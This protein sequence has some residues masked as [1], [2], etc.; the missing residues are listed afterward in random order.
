MAGWPRRPSVH[1][2]G[3]ALQPRHPHARHLR[4]IVAA[5]TGDAMRALLLG[6]RDVSHLPLHDPAIPWLVKASAGVVRTIVLD[7]PPVK[8]P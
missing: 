7:T 5:W 8:V 4:G 1:A 2:Q 3:V 6:H